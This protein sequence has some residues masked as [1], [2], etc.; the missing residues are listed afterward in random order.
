MITIAVAIVS[1]NQSI[2]VRSQLA[3]TEITSWM[4]GDKSPTSVGIRLEMYK[5]AIEKNTNQHYLKLRRVE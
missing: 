5:L 4:S 2:K 1:F 3:Y